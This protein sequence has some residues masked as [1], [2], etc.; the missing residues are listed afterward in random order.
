VLPPR[1]RSFIIERVSSSLARIPVAKR[2]HLAGVLGLFAVLFVAIGAV[3]ATGAD[4]AMLKAFVA[5]AFVVAVLL[6]L[7]A[8]GVVHSVSLELADQRVD[9][10]VSDAVAEAVAGGSTALQC[11]C[12][13]DHDPDELH[14]TDDPCAHDGAGV[15]CT[16]SCDTCVLSRLRSVP[17]SAALERPRPSPR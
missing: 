1:A 6:A 11:G 10:M 15:G 12:G 9:A 5:V 13:H 17:E 14:V 7:V 4:T 3:T 16:H 8:W 2:Q